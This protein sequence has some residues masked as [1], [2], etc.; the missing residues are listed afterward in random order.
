MRKHVLSY[1]LCTAALIAATPALAAPWERG[2]V[3]DAYEPAFYYGGPPLT[4]EEPGTDCPKG[5]VTAEQVA[6][7]GTT[8]GATLSAD[9]QRIR[10]SNPDRTFAPGIDVYM[11]P[12]TAPDPGQQEVTGKLAIGFNLDGD[13]NTGGFV[14]VNGEQGVDNQLYRILGC[15]I[16]YRGIP[17]NAHLSGRANDKMLQGL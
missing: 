13:A 6:A 3:V 2:F 5:T 17:Y 4:T 11:N 1:S 12:H 9:G 8:A 15:H 14:G 10:R 16:S 7:Q